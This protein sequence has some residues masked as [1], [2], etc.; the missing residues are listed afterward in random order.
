MLPESS[1][2]S[3]RRTN[4]LVEAHEPSV[5]IDSSAAA[6][7]MRRMCAS[8]CAAA[9]GAGARGPRAR[10]GERTAGAR[11]SIHTN[12]RDPPF[13]GSAQDSRPPDIEDAMT[14][15]RQSRYLHGTE[16]EEQRRLSGLNDLINASSL[17][18][19]GL[20]GGERVLD[21]GAGLGQLTRAIAR[22]VGPAGHVLGIERSEAQIAEARRLARSDGEE[23][24]LELRAGDVLELEL[25]R[26][27]WGSFDVAHARF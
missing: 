16:P 19:L 12:R 22:A 18:A 24:M 20:F 3:P 26:D 7:T 14:D 9:G 27:E 15:E 17:R 13:R 23:R 6:R 4:S 21:V 11:C 25:A 8:P 5:T 1:A 2:T 10:A